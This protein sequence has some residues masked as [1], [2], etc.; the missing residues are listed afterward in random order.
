MPALRELAAGHW[1]VDRRTNNQGLRPYCVVILRSKK[2]RKSVV[3][4]SSSDFESMSEYAETMKEDL[5]KLTNQEFM[6][7]YDLTTAM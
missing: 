7:K 5:E 6:T 4:A 1:E 2:N 3:K